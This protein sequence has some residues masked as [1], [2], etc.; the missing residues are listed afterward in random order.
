MSS[1]VCCILML[2]LSLSPMVSCDWEVIN[3][4]DEP[5]NFL[6]AE[7]FIPVEPV[8]KNSAKGNK[9]SLSSVK[10]TP[11]ADS[12]KDKAAET[13]P[14]PEASSAGSQQTNKAA[15]T[16][17]TTPAA[18]TEAKKVASDDGVDLKVEGFIPV[19]EKVKS[20]TRKLAQAADTNA[21]SN[22]DTRKNPESSSG[23]ATSADSEKERKTLIPRLKNIDE[24]KIVDIACIDKSSWECLMFKEDYMALK[25][26]WNLSDQ[27]LAKLRAKRQ[28]SNGNNPSS[29]ETTT[30]KTSATTMIQDLGS[31]Q[32]LY[33]S[34]VT[35]VSDVSISQSTNY[36]LKNASEVID[37]TR[38]QKIKAELE[39]QLKQLFKNMT[40]FIGV[41]IKDV[42]VNPNGEVEIQW[43]II[44]NGSDSGFL[45]GNITSILDKLFGELN[46][47]NGTFN[48]IVVTG[49]ELEG[50]LNI[51]DIAQQFENFFKN[52]CQG[53][54]CDN[55][56]GGCE[57]TKLDNRSPFEVTC[58]HNCILF[59]KNNNSCIH[60]ECELD[61]N[62]HA[63]CACPANWEGAFCESKVNKKLDAG[64]ITGVTLGAIAVTA[65]LLGC[66]FWFLAC[67]KSD[68]DIAFTHYSDEDGSGSFS[69]PS[70]KLSAFVIDRPKVSVN[71][72]QV[73]S[74]ANASS[75]GTAP[76]SQA[77]F[78]RRSSVG[79]LNSDDALVPPEPSTQYPYS[80]A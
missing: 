38:K 61:V 13:K 76:S 49:L 39:E 47:I 7:E 5:E 9:R 24:Q 64:Q 23:K 79:I 4:V 34:T 56:Y 37:A 12:D 63:I 62:F 67:R 17:T 26:D 35:K 10:T 51:T 31:G 55:G 69:N 18:E 48:K 22:D 8:S 74:S 57:A 80:N 6:L 43:Q 32:E 41:T 16:S 2:V 65:G 75:V 28:A 36:K 50:G 19:E 66:C 21:E 73:F 46:D 53:N 54:P 29:T 71:P 11:K 77:N 52:P 59:E 70:S 72:F 25:K 1:L 20:P 44:V 15:T 68:R 33:T 78:G 3:D 45:N 42:L 27:A 40:G 30:T 60:G 14:L 58:F